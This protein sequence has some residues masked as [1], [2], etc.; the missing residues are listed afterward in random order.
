MHALDKGY[1]DFRNGQS[2]MLKP[3]DDFRVDGPALRM[4][5]KIDNDIALIQLEGGVDTS[6]LE[7]KC[8]ARQRLE[9]KGL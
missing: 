2:A 3:V 7:A 5:R 4:Q 9:S 8:Q 1:G 6:S